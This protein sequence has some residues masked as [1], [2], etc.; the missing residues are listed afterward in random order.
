M[1]GHPK[2][3]GPDYRLSLH[4][5][6]SLPGAIVY[7]GHS[8]LIKR[9]INYGRALVGWS[10]DR[11]REDRGVREQATSSQ[12]PRRTL[13]ATGL[14]VSAL[15]AG[16]APLGGVPASYASLTDEDKALATVRA[17]L[18]SPINFM[19]TAAL[20]GDGESERRIGVVLRERGGLPEGVVLATKIGWDPQ[21]D[22][23]D[24]DSTQRRLERSLRLLGLDRLQLV[25][26][27]DPEHRTF[28]E[29]TA[30]G[31]PLAVLQRAKEDGLITNLGI[32]GG[33]I[34]L[35]SRFVETGLFTVAIS[36][37]RFTLLNRAADPFWDLCRRQG[38]AALNAAPYGGGILA[39]GPDVY[40]RYAYRP[41]SEDLLARARRIE[42]SCKA[43]DVP[44]A[45]VALQFSLRDPRI[46]STILGIGA[47]SELDATLALAAQPVPE[48]LW[49][50]LAAIPFDDADFRE[51]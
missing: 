5:P 30:P 37:N 39:L 7:H 18:D 15:C 25:Y 13:G 41:A 10:N 49:L 44:L 38:V 24:G 28:E 42:A 34:S 33:P 9:Y 16:C 20:Y 51:Y 27:H 47:P 50:E 26:L 29:I 1:D 14:V 32:A 36:H 23:F 31:G 21:T 35:M 2:R 11:G 22:V 8:Y 3:T 4:A 43:F 45:A 48:A 40:P 6:S 17:I 19:D 12:V 46:T